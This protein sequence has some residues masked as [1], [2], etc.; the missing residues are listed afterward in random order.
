LDDDEE[1]PAGQPA[2]RVPAG[3]PGPEGNGRASPRS[4]KEKRR[5]AKR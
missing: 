5:S 3:K 2:R 4:G 1:P